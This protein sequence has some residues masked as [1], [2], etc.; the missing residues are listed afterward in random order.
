MRKVVRKD[1][2]KKKNGPSKE[3]WSDRHKV[4]ISVVAIISFVGSIVFLW[5]MGP[6]I[7]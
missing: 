1:A 5:I 7:K 2:P 4:L 3:H 6:H